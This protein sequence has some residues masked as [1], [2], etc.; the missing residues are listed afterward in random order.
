MFNLML[1]K[2][3]TISSKQVMDCLRH[4]LMAYRLH[5]PELFGDLGSALANSV[6]NN[7]RAPRTGANQS[8]WGG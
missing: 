5:L 1:Q 4:L 8:G 6:W 2:L 7:W 3:Q